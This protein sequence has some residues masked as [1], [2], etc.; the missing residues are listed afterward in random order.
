MLHIEL[1]SLQIQGDAELSE[2][3]ITVLSLERFIFTV[4]FVSWY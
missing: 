1:V 4:H 3:R 2:G